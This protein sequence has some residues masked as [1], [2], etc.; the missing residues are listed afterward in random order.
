MIFAAN[1]LTDP[2]SE[3]GT[4]LQKHT[5][6]AAIPIILADKGCTRPASLRLLNL[7]LLNI[8]LDVCSDEKPKE[9]SYESPNKMFSVAQPLDPWHLSLPPWLSVRARLIG[10]L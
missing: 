5:T 9:N 8:I 3:D 1:E 6:H 4:W 2:F 7:K 10:W